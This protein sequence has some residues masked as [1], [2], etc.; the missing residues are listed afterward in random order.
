MAQSDCSQKG[1]VIATRVENTPAN[2]LTCAEFVLDMPAGHPRQNEQ[3]FC[4]SPQK[5]KAPDSSWTYDASGRV[6]KMVQDPYPINGSA[7][8]VPG[9]YWLVVK[10]HTGSIHRSNPMRIARK[11]YPHCQAVSS[12]TPTNTPRCQWSGIVA[13]PEEQPTQSC[14]TSN[15]G[16]TA[17]N[18]RGT[19]FTC[20]CK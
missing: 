9:T 3:F 11:G 1:A 14:S 5:F 13:G 10:D 6:W 4:D 12:G 15:V 18:T 17:R 7:F 8:L 16:A 19:V 2:I 20:E